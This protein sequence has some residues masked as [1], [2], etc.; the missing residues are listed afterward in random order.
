MGLFPF[1]SCRSDVFSFGVVLWEL[2]TLQKPWEGMNPMQVVGAVGYQGA[3][4]AIP[5]YLDSTIAAMIEACWSRYHISTVEYWYRTLVM[6]TWTGAEHE[7]LPAC[8]ML[9]WWDWYAVVLQEPRSVPLCRI[10]ARPQEVS[11]LRR[12]AISTLITL[13]CDIKGWHSS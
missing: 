9:I 3:R 4:L 2:C 5:D 8:T 6:L 10:G 1:G 12:S 11:G 13:P 7:M